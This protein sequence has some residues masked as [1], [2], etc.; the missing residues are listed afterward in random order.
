[1][2]ATPSP[3]PQPRPAA[4]AGSLLWLLLVA[5]TVADAA[6]LGWAWREAT[7]AG[8]VG[9]LRDLRQDPLVA[10]FVFDALAL[11]TG[12]VVAMATTGGRLTIW[13]AFVPVG[14]A[15]FLIADALQRHRRT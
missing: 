6:L 8:W 4:P 15:P 11:R 1:M 2:A 9:F 12:A 7:L 10:L 5:V 13:L 14:G 3:L